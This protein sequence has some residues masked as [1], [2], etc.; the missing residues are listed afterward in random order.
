MDKRDA[1]ARHQEARD[2]LGPYVLGALEPEEER[3]VER[4]LASCAAC[5]EEERGLRETHERLSGAAIARA[6][7][8]PS[9]KQRVLSALSPRDGGGAL[10]TGEPRRTRRLSWIAVAA[11]AAILVFALAGYSA[12][13]FGSTQT[14]SLAPT[15]IAPRAGGE[16]KVRDSGPVAEATLEVWGL[17]RCNSREY[18]ELWFG[19]E[20]G[21]VS[22]GTFKVDEEGRGTLSVSAPKLDGGYERVGITLEEFPEEPSME[23][24]RVVLRGELPES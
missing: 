19:R 7:A 1:G 8:P 16:L 21:R 24:A 5:R 22:A 9:L 23:S 12:G 10:P 15:E 20:G 2:L 13:L 6:A 14:A 4:H 18:Y 3:E 11:A 17:P